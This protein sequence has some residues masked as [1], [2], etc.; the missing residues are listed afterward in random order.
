MRRRKVLNGISR[1]SVP[2]GVQG[3]SGEPRDPGQWCVGHVRRFLRC[4]CGSALG[5][6][7]RGKNEECRLF[8]CRDRDVNVD[9]RTRARLMP[10]AI[11][12][13]AIAGFLAAGGFFLL[14][15][16]RQVR[17]RRQC[18]N[19]Y[20]CGMRFSGPQHSMPIAASWPLA[21][22][23]FHHDKGATLYYSPW[24]SV[25]LSDVKVVEQRWRG[26]GSIVAVEATSSEG[27][28]VEVR[29]Y[30]TQSIEIAGEF[31]RTYPDASVR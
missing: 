18:E 8:G 29:I 6:R 25:F 26:T 11:I 2:R 21:L 10:V 31:A 27:A 3:G 13:V 12:V 24:R 23:C 14:A 15:L 22:V 4:L 19:S 5:C 9:S 30:S 1:N 28:R 16:L 7:W 20:L 17:N